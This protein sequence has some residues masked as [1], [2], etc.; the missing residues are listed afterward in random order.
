MGIERQRPNVYCMVCDT[1]H[2]T[3]FIT[4]IL[5]VKILPHVYE[6]FSLHVWSVCH[7]CFGCAPGGQKRALNFLE[8]QTVVSLLV[9]AGNGTQVPREDSRCANH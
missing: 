9:S 2:N 4:L 7:V 3:N 6:Y 5:L 1:M 8:L